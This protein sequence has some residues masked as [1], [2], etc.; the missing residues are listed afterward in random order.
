MIDQITLELL[1]N[2]SPAFA[3]YNNTGI[4][5]INPIVSGT[6]ETG[7]RVQVVYPPATEKGTISV[8]LRKPSKHVFSH[9]SYIDSGFYDFL[10]KKEKDN[11]SSD[12]S[13]FT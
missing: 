6:L 13:Y 2:F 8:T 3:G 10:I 1:E 11:D 7:E 5:D 4:S 12:R 9:Q